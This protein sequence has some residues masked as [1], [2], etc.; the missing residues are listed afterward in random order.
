MK[1]GG[2]NERE[3]D[4][5]EDGGAAMTREKGEVEGRGPRVKGGRE[6]K[7]KGEKKEREERGKEKRE[8]K[9]EG[10][11]R[12]REDAG[13]VEEEKKGRSTKGVEEG[14]REGNKGTREKGRKG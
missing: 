13:W 10:E 3:R 2:W 5:V 7:R 4:A 14:T 1:K 11:E 6:T 9:R 12:K 8:R